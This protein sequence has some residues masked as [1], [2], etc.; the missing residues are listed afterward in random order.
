MQVRHVRPTIVSLGDHPRKLSVIPVCLEP[1]ALP[2]P[3]RA[4]QGRPLRGVWRGVWGRPLHLLIGFGSVAHIM[5]R[6]HCCH[7]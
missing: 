2:Q 1:R 7:T 6:L 3:V 4:A 5:D